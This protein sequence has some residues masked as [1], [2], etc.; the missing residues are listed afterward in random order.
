MVTAKDLQ[1]AVKINLEDMNTRHAGPRLGVHFTAGQV[2][3][4]D[5]VKPVFDIVVSPVLSRGAKSSSD[6]MMV[7]YRQQLGLE[8]TTLEKVKLSGEGH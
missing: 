8:V 7:T 5:T 4:A 3:T 6:E 1:R 2:P